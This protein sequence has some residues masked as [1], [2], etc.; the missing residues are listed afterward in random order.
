MPHPGHE[1]LRRHAGERGGEHVGGVA[2]IVEAK[3]VLSDRPARGLPLRRPVRSA[4]VSA[5]LA[6]EHVSVGARL[7]PSL[8]VLLEVW[9]EDRWDVHGSI[10]GLGLRRSDYDPRA[11]LLELLLDGHRQA[12]EVYM[13]APQ[14]QQPTHPY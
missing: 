12:D 10:A 3:L 4:D 1:I 14:A 13:S 7:R 2:E 8:E 6:D 5:P 11:D 9:N